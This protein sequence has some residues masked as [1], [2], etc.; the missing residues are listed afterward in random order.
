MTRHFGACSYTLGILYLVRTHSITYMRIPCMADCCFRFFTIT[1]KWLVSQQS[2][3]AKKICMSNSLIFLLF[4]NCD[5]VLTSFIVFWNI[6]QCCFIFIYII[7]NIED[8]AIS[9]IRAFLIPYSKELTHSFKLDLLSTVK[10][11]WWIQYGTYIG[12]KY[13]A[14]RK[15]KR[16][17]D[18]TI[19][20]CTCMHVVACR[21][22]IT[23]QKQR[24]KIKGIKDVYAFRPC[25]SYAQGMQEKPK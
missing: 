19:M 13:Y 11:S 21:L 12:T 17:C 1:S 18:S 23:S 9:P 10:T 24:Y 8:R 14:Y 15:Y 22:Q 6:A 5:L 20:L 7:C 2:I 25:R 16:I 4:L 3:V